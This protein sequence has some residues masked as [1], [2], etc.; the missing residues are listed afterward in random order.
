[1]PVK[2]R[3]LELRSTRHAARLLKQE[4]TNNY[5]REHNE[6]QAI[7]LDMEYPEK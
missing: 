3:V 2:E 6:H 4:K 7:V 5:N 1:M